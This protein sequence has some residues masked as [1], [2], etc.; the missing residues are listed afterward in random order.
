[1]RAGLYPGT[2]IARFLG[3]RDDEIKALVELDG[4]PAVNVPAKTKPI[5][6]VALAPFHAWLEQ[7]SQNTALTIEQLRDELEL[8]SEQ[9]AKRAEKTDTL[10]REH[11]AGEDE[12]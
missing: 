6:K 7:R 4:L 10:K 12:A 5:L 11:P 9:S 2:V 3:K 8:V 1:M